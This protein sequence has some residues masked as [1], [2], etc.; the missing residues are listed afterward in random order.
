MLLHVD[1]E[2]RDEDLST[3]VSNVMSTAS[4][5]QAWLA[6][7]TGIPLATLNAWL[8]RRRTPGRSQAASDQLHRLADVLIRLDSSIVRARVFEAA[9]RQIPRLSSNEQRKVWE[10]YLELSPGHQTAVDQLIE[11]LHS[12]ER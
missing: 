12:Q 10:R 9:G 2:K 3:L 11:T 5:T 4:V 7:E 1:A 6:E 8:T